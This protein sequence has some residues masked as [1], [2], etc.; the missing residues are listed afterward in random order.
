MIKN[1]FMVVVLVLAT[2]FFKLSAQHN[3]AHNPIIFADVPDMSMIRVGKN[4]FMSS[5]TMHM[6]PGVPI[7]K[8]EDLVN[9]KL[10]NYAY[11]TLGDADDLNLNNGKSMYSRGSWASCIRYHKETYYVSTFSGNT[12]KTYIYKTKDIEKGPWE[13]ISFSPYIHDQTLFFDDDGKTYIIWGVKKLRIAELKDDLS[14]VKEGTEKVL[15]ENANIPSGADSGLGEGSQLFKVNGKYY[16]FI[17][18]WP[19]GGMRT[20]VIHRADNIQGPWEGK[21]ALQDLGV[22]QGG[23]IDTPEGNWYAYLFRDFGAVGRIPY[24]VPVS[25]E[26]GWPVLGKEGKVPESLEELPASKGIIPGIVASD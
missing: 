2:A 12:G 23:L 26:N 13:T 16:L 6:S 15:I 21:L 7:M 4:Y 24:L 3:S 11:E 20:V 17:I 25:W 8:S 19:R 9:W 5:T 18:T 1:V 10:V 22:A 14:G